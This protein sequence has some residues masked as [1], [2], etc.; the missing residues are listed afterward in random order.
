MPITFFGKYDQVGFQGD[1][2]GK[3]QLGSD[4]INPTPLVSDEITS[5]AR[6]LSLLAQN[7]LEEHLNYTS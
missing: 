7:M 4:A 5:F 6:N 2:A 1:G 3:T